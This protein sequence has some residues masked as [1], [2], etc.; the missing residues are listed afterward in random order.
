[1]YCRMLSLILNGPLAAGA[2][3][4]GSAYHRQTGR[5]L[6][7]GRGCTVTRCRGS[8]RTEL[9]RATILSWTGLCCSWCFSTLSLL[10]T[11]KKQNISIIFCLCHFVCHRYLQLFI[12]LC[13]FLFFALSLTWEIG[14]LFIGLELVVWLVSVAIQCCP[15]YAGESQKAISTSKLR[16]SALIQQVIACFI[17]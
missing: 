1:M 12:A 14:L 15:L 13:T 8:G 5:P 7:Q 10:D 16:S 4:C 3:I 9:R 17:H 11:H 6:F 2:C